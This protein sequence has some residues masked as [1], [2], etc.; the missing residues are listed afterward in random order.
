MIFTYEVGMRV[1]TREEDE[2]GTIAEVA[3][4][5]EVS[6]I[7]DGSEDQGAQWCEARDIIPDT[8]EALQKLTELNKK[9]QANIDEAT[10]LLEQAFKKWRLANAMEMEGTDSPG[11]DRNYYEGAYA[12]RSN[13]DLDL[14]KFEEVVENNGWS[15][16]SLYC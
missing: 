4:Y 2:H 8:P 15:T 12:L 3:A 5:D 13:S 14:S 11:D 7:W 10:T 9:I 1:R 6:V 16:S